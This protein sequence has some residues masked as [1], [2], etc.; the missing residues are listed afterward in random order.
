MDSLIF[1]VPGKPQPKQRARRGRGGKWYTPTQ[2]RLF[3]A[4]VASYA[5]VTI[6]DHPMRT[7]RGWNPSRPFR[8]TVVCYMPD[9]RRRDADNVAKAVLDACNG[10]LWDDDNQ[11]IDLRAIKAHDADNPRTAVTV[12][13]IDRPPALFTTRAQRIADILEVTTNG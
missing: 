6:N 9:K 10:I 1:T 3:E 7:I 11:V 12:E 5:R 2:T 4:S 8:V 13:A